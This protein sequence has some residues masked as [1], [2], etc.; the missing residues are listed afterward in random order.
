M[1]QITELRQEMAQNHSEMKDKK[2]SI[3]KYKSISV[4]NQKIKELIM[5]LETAPKEDFLRSERIRMEGIVTAKESQYAHWSSNI[6][7]DSVEVKNR[8]SMFNT[9]LGLVALKRQIKTLSY[10]LQ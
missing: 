9:E 4:K 6:C 1:L 3:K 5:Y 7:P 10:I 8:R 2:T